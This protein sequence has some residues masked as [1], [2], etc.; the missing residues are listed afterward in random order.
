MQSDLTRRQF[1]ARSAASAALVLTGLRGRARAMQSPDG[2]RLNILWIF[3]DDLGPELGC[4]GNP[5]VH[6]PHIDRLAAEGVRFTRAFTTAPVCSASRSAMAT[7]MYQTAIGAHNHRSHRD[8]GYRLPGGII[9]VAEH[10]AAA[11]YFTCNDKDTELSGTGKNDYN[12]QCDQPFLGTDWRQRADGQPFY[13]QINFHPPHRKFKP[14]PQHPIDP[15]LIQLTPYY[16]DD[17]IARQDYALYL[18]HVQNLDHLVGHALDRLEADGLAQN[19][20]VFFIGDNGRP[21]FRD[22]QFLY[23]GGLHVPLIVRWPERIVPG[24]VRDDLVSAID[25]TASSLDI[26]GLNVPDTMHGRSLFA[27]D[28]QPRRYIFGARDRCD[29]TVDRIRSVRNDRYKL[30]RNYMPDR[31]YMQDN[32]YKQQQYPDWELIKQLKAEGKL[33]PQQA[34]FAADSRPPQELYD[35]QTDPHELRN[36]VDDP[37][38]APVLW[39]LQTV[40]DEWIEQTHDQGAI[41]EESMSATT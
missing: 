36:L 20:A 26:A 3:G 24:S 39:E 5:L 11:G 32:R 22:K 2:R 33:T 10:F 16:P 6:T 19:T 23:E 4:Y 30:I 34:L 12:F 31:P 1:L 29:E 35:L 18:E 9:T 38:Y 14:D 37:Q 40:L 28:R 17:P 27:P 13:G 8:D 15:D 25:M 7:G 41:P 21:H